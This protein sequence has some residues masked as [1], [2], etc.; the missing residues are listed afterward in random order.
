MKFIQTTD[1]GKAGNTDGLV[2]I[3][4]CQRQRSI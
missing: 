4:G 1:K 2:T 3:G